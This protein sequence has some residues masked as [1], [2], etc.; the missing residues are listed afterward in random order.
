MLAD[1]RHDVRL[2]NIVDIPLNYQ[3]VFNNDQIADTTDWTAPCHHYQA[4]HIPS[5]RYRSPRLK[6]RESRYRR[7]HRVIIALETHLNDDVAI[8]GADVT[9]IEIKGHSNATQFDV[10][11]AGIPQHSLVLDYVSLVTYSQLL[12]FCFFVALYLLCKSFNLEKL[13]RLGVMI[14]GRSVQGR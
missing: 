12:F 4:C 1:E 7:K 8:I 11:G 13:S 6:K 9:L 2:Q 5:C 3:I 14:F 10:I